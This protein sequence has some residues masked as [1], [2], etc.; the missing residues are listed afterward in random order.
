MMMCVSIEEEDRGLEALW[1]SKDPRGLRCRES[2]VGGGFG[3]TL[4]CELMI[5]MQW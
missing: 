3:R 1:W 2:E 4:L 5:M